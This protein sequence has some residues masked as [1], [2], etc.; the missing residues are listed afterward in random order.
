MRYDEL[1]VLFACAGESL[2]G[3]VARPAQPAETGVL[4]IVGGPQYRVGSHR[5][6]VHLSRFLAGEGIACMRFDYRGMGDS[7]GAMRTF[8]EVSD[9]IGAAL[10]A[11]FAMLPEL[12]RVV[13]W[14]LCDAA[15]AACFYAPGDARVAGVALLNPWVRTEAGEATAYLRHYYVQRL[16][17]GAFWRKLIGGGVRFGDSARGLG[18]NIA[19]A[20]ARTAESPLP[21]R[22]G[23]CLARFKGDILVVLSEVDL[24]AAEFRDAAKSKPWQRVL[25]AS[26][27]QSRRIAGATHTFS[28]EAWRNEVACATLEWVRALPAGGAAQ[29]DC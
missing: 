2:L 1:P 22:M 10:D 16:L 13:L 21:A 23:E 4:V 6:F 7:S 12:K 3:I 18:G 20:G 11:F 15:S 19:R 28:S 17:S 24:V 9:D 29:P 27:T 8:E 25:E 14:G 5:Q 26:R